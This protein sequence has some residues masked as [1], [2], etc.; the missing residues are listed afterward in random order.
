[1]TTLFQKLKAKLT[2]DLPTPEIC[3]RPN[4]SVEVFP[5]KMTAKKSK[6]KGPKPKTTITSL[7]WY[8][9]NYIFAIK[10]TTKR[11]PT[12]HTAQDVVRE[13][14][15]NIND[16]GEV[17]INDSLRF[18]EIGAEE[19]FRGVRNVPAKCRD[20]VLGCLGLGKVMEQRMENGER[21]EV[22][23]GRK[24]ESLICT[25]AKAKGGGLCGRKTG[26]TTRVVRYDGT[27][28]LSWECSTT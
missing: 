20:R 16:A 21:V 10:L 23:L 9:D 19:G 2:R 13:F 18:R 25:A 27:E 12:C 7:P 11:C 5:S 4:S 24:R 26:W 14:Q 17:Q 22:I 15:R 28:K 8:P 1:M 3:R 6:S